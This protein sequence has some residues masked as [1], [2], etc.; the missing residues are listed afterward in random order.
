[1][2]WRLPLPI[3]PP[4]PH[5]PP[6]LSPARAQIASIL[7][8]REVDCGVD[9]VGFEAR[10]CGAVGVRSE[11]PAS[12]LNGM[13]NI[14][15]AGGAVGIPG[16]YVTEDPGAVEAAAK[17]GSLSLRLGLGWAKS[18]S[19]FTGQAPVIKYHRQLMQAILFDRVKIADAVNVKLISL[20]DAPAGYANFDQGASVK[21]VIDPHGEARKHLGVA[22]S[23]L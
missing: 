3:P 6:S 5:P 21:Y 11:Q 20:D 17:Q 19:F 13:F 7:G 14:V 15:K 10:G 22:K 8:T 18:M 9:A 12:V 4:P 16:L 23:Q 2:T 1:M